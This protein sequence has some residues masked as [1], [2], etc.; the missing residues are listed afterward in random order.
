MSKIIKIIKIQMTR[1]QIGI[2]VAIAAIIAGGIVYFGAIRKSTPKKQIQINGTAEKTGPTNPGNVSPISGL[3]CENWNRRAFAVMQPSDVPARPAA[4]FYDADMVFE[5]P[6]IT[7]SI[8]RLMGVYICGSPDDIGSMRSARHDYIA[9]AKG[10]DAIFVHWGGSHYAIDK[11]N[12]GVIDDMNCNNDGG[13]SADK[14]CYRKEASGNMRGVDTGYTKYAKLLEGAQNFGYRLTNNFVGYPHQEELALEQRPN[15][16]RIRVVF[17]KPFDAEFDYDK[18]TNSYLRSWNDK[19]DTDRNNDKRIAPKNV[20]VLI[21]EST[22]IVEGEQYNNVQ[23]GDPWYDS[24]DSG[25][26]FFY[27]N[28]QQIEGTW[29]KDKSKLDSKLFFYDNSGQEIK[30][31][32]GQIWV[33]VLEPGQKL[34]WQPAA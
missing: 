9:L 3:P 14:Y 15:G 13:K 7:N 34:D 27:M 22:Q 11:L 10:L 26:G 16:G 29:K 19:A 24:T 30:F 25:K 17:A 6:V 21:A 12:E 4:G 32:P 8:T 20:V 18:A 23:I 28:G 33:D 5:M 31:V 1:K 2:I